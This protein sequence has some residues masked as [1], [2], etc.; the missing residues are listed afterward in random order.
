MFGTLISVESQ[1]ELFDAAETLKFRRINE[2]NDQAP[3]SV[4]AEGNDV[5][6]RIAINPLGQFLG[7]VIEELRQPQSNTAP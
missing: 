4:I 5:V 1:P 3:L 7:L 6:D 2:P